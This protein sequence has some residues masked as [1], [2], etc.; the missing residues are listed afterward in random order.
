MR[1]AALVSP[2][3]VARVVVVAFML[4]FM[5]TRSTHHISMVSTIAIC[6]FI[7]VHQT[8]PHTYTQTCTLSTVGRCDLYL[9]G[10]SIN[11]ARVVKRARCPAKYHTAQQDQQKCEINT[12]LNGYTYI[13]SF[14]FSFK[15]VYLN[16]FYLYVLLLILYTIKY[17]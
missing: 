14:K 6:A 1:R 5:R 10:S 9:V 15:F 13:R 17:Q 4:C 11:G 3:M 12:L 16:A 8:S 2:F 7:C